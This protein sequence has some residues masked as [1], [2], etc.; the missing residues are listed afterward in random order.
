[1]SEPRHKRKTKA[2][3]LDSRALGVN[4]FREGNKRLEYR[5]YVS[6]VRIILYFAAPKLQYT[7]ISVTMTYFLKSALRNRPHK[8]RLILVSRNDLAL[9]FIDRSPYP[10]RRQ[11]PTPQPSEQNTIHKSFS[12]D[13]PAIL[14]YL[15]NTW[16][17][18]FIT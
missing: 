17:P 5:A 7:S 16:C 18:L 3:A 9:Y 10:R 15:K 13:F 2:N 6:L 11:I 8:T 14:K 12:S 4:G 1:M